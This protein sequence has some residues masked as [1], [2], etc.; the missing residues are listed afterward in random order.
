VGGVFRGGIVGT[1]KWWATIQGGRGWR[2]GGGPGARGGWG[3]RARGGSSSGV[4]KLG[5]ETRGLSRG[6]VGG[7]VGG[8][9]GGWVGGVVG[10]RRG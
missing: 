10:W 9:G 5:I 6:G 4:R 1:C 8:R 3:W 2:G 7:G